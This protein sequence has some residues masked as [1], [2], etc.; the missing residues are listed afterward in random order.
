MLACGALR[1]RTPTPLPTDV[2]LVDFH[3]HLFGVGDGNSGC[4]L[5]Q[6]QRE[7]W[8]FN[9]LKRL[10]EI[11][12][13]RYPEDPTIDEQ[14]VQ[15]LVQHVR[16]SSVDRVLLQSWD[17]RYTKGKLDLKATTSL[18]VPNEYLFRV[19]RQYPDLLLACASINPSRADALEHLAY[20]I[21]QGARAIKIHPPTMN[22]DPG[23]PAFVPFYEL[24]HKHNIIVMVHTGMEHAA[25][26]VG[27]ENCD[28]VK[29]KPALEVGCT[30]IAAHA[31]FGQF[32][33]REDFY[34]SFERMVEDHPR[35]YADTSIL[36]SLMRW[37][38][39]PRLLNNPDALSRLVFGT[40]YPFA[41]NALVFWN[42]LNIANLVSLC[43]ERN[44]F[45]RDLQLKRHLGLPSSH[46]RLGAQ[47]LGLGT[48]S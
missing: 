15:R 41:S 19:V 37:R 24:C 42:R 36:T 11:E 33:D 35:L 21:E 4:H 45:E 38:N 27:F 28:P 6:K 30:V 40:D 12:D 48:K 14:L 20:C 43:A 31:G 1:Q 2:P 10:L 9:Y 18:Y 22:V 46:F 8:T 39:I 32:H 47:L 25:D 7:H 44:L 13:P 5:H 26:V 3:A 17:G 23:N 34:P 29:L 16:A